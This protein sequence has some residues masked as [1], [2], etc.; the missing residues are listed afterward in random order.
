M[1]LT[2]CSTLYR[3]VFPKWRWKGPS[4]KGVYLTF[5]DGP[6]PEVTPLVLSILKTHDVKAT[7]FCVGENAEKFPELIEQ[8]KA[9]GHRIGNHTHSHEHGWKTPKNLYLKSV[10]NAAQSIDS[11]LF[12]PPYGKMK[13]SSA[14]QLR[15]AGFTIVMW[16][17]LSYD[18]KQNL[19]ASRIIQKANH[20]KGGDIL[21]FHD[22]QK[23]LSKISKMLPEIIEI[24]TQK[25][26]TF[27][28]I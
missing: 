19:T 15:E 1:I 6:D 9:D 27:E 14:K 25:N 8:I 13:L 26:L 7:F 24:I 4:K 20:I 5:D 17:W 23:A 12:R 2:D 10:E 21:L 18:Y 3:W 22:S 11:T 16:S 28:L